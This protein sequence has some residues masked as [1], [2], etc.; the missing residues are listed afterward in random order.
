MFLAGGAV[1]KVAPEATAFVHREALMLI[2]IDL[3]WS[4][5]DSPKTIAANQ[6]WL[7]A[8]HEAMRP[9]RLVEIKGKYDPANLFRFAQS[10]P[11]GL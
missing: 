3:E 11:L 6:T 2:T 9:Y 1:A 7:A 4:E 8:F 5:E 10:I